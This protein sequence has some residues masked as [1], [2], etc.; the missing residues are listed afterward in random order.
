MRK[1]RKLTD[2][3]Q[4]EE[5]FSGSS[6]AEDKFLEA[7]VAARIFK[8]LY[9][10]VALLALVFAGRISYF[11]WYRDFFQN[12]AV[13]NASSETIIPAGRGIIFDRLGMPLAQNKPTFS[14]SLK[15]VDYKKNKEEIDTFLFPALGLRADE[16]AALI[17]T[18]DLEQ[19][20]SV[21]IAK[22]LEPEQLINLRSKEVTGLEIRA[23]F[24]RYYPKGPATSHI[25]GYVD[26]TGV[27]KTG[28]ELFYNN[29]LAGSD[30]VI[31]HQ[32]N[33][34]GELLA[35]KEASRPQ[36]GKDLTITIDGEFQ[37]YL[38]DRIVDGLRQLGRKKAVG[39]AMNPQTGEILAAVSVPSFDGNLFTRRGDDGE[40]DTKNTLLRSAD[41]PLFNRFVSGLYN[42][43]STI[44]PLVA[45]GALKE[46]VI[47]P[48]RGIYSNGYIEL[49]NPY[50]PAHPSR[51]LDAKPHGTVD[52]YSALA[53]SSNVYFYEV[54]GGFEDI[55]GLGINRLNDWWKKFG[56]GEKT[57]IDLPAEGKGFLPNPDEKEKRTG[58]PWRIGDTYN[59]SIGQG[60]LQ[61]TPIQLLNYIAA[62]ANGGRLYEPHLKKD[63]SPKLLSDL[64]G[65]QKEIRD[66][67]RGMRDG[68]QKPYGLLNSLNDLPVVVAGKTGTAQVQNNQKTNAFFA[69]FAPY[70]YDK[71]EAQIAILLVVEDAKEGSL[72]VIPIAKDVFNWYY[73][74]RMKQSQ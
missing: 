52:L 8:I 26:S 38:Y 51:F 28:L 31:L 24:S 44:K 72:N 12:R 14:A 39:L 11:W 5:I 45:V 29:I 68:V 34:K 6:M 20:D 21:L 59:V 58:T 62:I 17:K 67:Q 56:L 42:P 74:H 16:M 71:N 47:T 40:R 10:A 32:K 48:D 1:K 60:D 15:L 64:A 57:G 73:E 27:P 35:D 19:A 61:L 53:V 63:S 9:V 65:L 22:D 30:G 4:I 36:D 46:G 3:L 23:D 43:G 7:K 66:V 41:Q 33:S 2:N 69:G 70:N 55:K 50:D 49:P 37:Q 25:L 54:G 13:A 18:A